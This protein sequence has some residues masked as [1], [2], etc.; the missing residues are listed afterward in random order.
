MVTSF[1]T[2]MKD[3]VLY[4]GS[5]SEPF[6]INSGVKQGCVLAPTLFGI[7]FSM[8]LS[9][10]FDSSTDGVYLHTMSD[11][12]LFNLARLHSKPKVRTVLIREMLYADDA[13]LVTHTED[14]LQRQANRLA[15]A[16][17]QFGLTISLKTIN[18][19]AQDVSTAPSITIDN[20]KL[21]TVDEFTYL[22]ST[23]SNNLSLD[24]ELDRRL[25]KSNTIMARLTKRVWE[26]TALTLH[27]KIRVYQACVLSTLLHGSESWTTYIKQELRLNSFYMRC[28]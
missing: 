10:A 17:K 2:N 19:S 5:S 26:N 15:D 21:D 28:L 6:S 22:G 7:F 3:T 12:K 11:G 23:I 25:G 8:L 16:C 20:V 1:H 24:I 9:H 14:A 13:A 27:T 18:I 4:D